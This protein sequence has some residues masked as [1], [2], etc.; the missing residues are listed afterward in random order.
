MACRPSSA[1][2]DLTRERHAALCEEHDGPEMMALYQTLRYFEKNPGGIQRPII[3]TVEL[4]Q[5]SVDSYPF[6]IVV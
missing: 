3:V 1:Q 6:T 2:A 4:A 5:C